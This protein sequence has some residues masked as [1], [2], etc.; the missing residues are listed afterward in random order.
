VK[1]VEMANE[2]REHLLGATVIQ[3]RPM[4]PE[5]MAAAGWKDERPPQVVIFDDGTKMYA[6]VDAEGN[7]PGELMVRPKGGEVG[8]L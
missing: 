8:V 3:V 4:F 1:G 7:G 5:E 2:L 6:S